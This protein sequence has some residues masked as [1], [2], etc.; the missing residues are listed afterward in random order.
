MV[1]L[2]IHS[3]I[4]LHGVVLNALNFQLA[5]SLQ[6]SDKIFESISMCPTHICLHANVAR[7]IYLCSDKRLV[8]DSV[9]MDHCG[10]D[11]VVGKQG[12]VH[13]ESEACFR[14]IGMTS[15]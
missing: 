7:M 14:L 13:T 4:R 5:A 11:L 12:K 6:A 8:L 10:F 2:Y 1:E 15:Y 3:H 9:I